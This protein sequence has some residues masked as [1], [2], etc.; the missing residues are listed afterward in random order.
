MTEISAKGASL[1][2]KIDG[3]V[4]VAY[5]EQYVNALYAV[6]DYISNLEVENSALNNRLEAVVKVGNEMAAA[7]VFSVCDEDVFRVTFEKVN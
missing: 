4:Q 3:N 5:E 6:E 2:N 7:G 1:I